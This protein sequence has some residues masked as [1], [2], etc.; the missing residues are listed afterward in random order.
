VLTSFS[1]DGK[2]LSYLP[3]L[4]ER[5]RV[6]VSLRYWSSQGRRICWNLEIKI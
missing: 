3:T 5:L 1:R 4:Y 6:E 2:S